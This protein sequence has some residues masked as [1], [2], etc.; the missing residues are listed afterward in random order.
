[1]SLLGFLLLQRFTSMLRLFFGAAIH[2]TPPRKPGPSPLSAVPAAGSG[3]QAGAWT[4]GASPEWKQNSL[5]PTSLNR[6]R[7]NVGP[8]AASAYLD[9]P[10]SGLCTPQTAGKR[11]RSSRCQQRWRRWRIGGIKCNTT[12]TMLAGTARGNQSPA[13][14]LSLLGK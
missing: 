8:C 6:L 10:Q 14:A 5:P 11:P 12:T 3:R 9:L 13:G 4:A 7:A 1:M 2:K